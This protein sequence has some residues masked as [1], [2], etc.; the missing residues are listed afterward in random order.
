LVTDI[1]GTTEVT[2]GMYILYMNLLLVRSNNITR[3]KLFLKIK[4]IMSKRLCEAFG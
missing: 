3:T 2:F 4:L 1:P